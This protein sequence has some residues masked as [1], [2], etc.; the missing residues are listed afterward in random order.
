[1]IQ[2]CNFFLI[3]NHLHLH[4]AFTFNGTFQKWFAYFWWITKIEAKIFINSCTVC[5]YCCQLLPITIP[6]NFF[7]WSDDVPVMT[8][9]LICIHHGDSILHTCLR[10]VIPCRGDTRECSLLIWYFEVGKPLESILLCFIYTTKEKG[11]VFK[12][13]P[14]LCPCLMNN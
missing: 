7:I 6:P 8:V 9:H 1:M 4:Q 10:G 11:M 5:R 3:K 13:I 12:N 14:I 2:D